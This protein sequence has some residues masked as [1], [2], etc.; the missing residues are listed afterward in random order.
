MG[1]RFTSRK[2]IL[3]LLFAAI[4]CIDAWILD[5]RSLSTAELALIGSVLGIYN[6]TNAITSR[7]A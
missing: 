2:F 5:S 4:V 6:I 3:S 7:G 1:S